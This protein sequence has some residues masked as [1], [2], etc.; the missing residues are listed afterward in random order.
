MELVAD[1]IGLLASPGTG[2]VAR[3]LDEHP[4]AQERLV[5]RLARRLESF[6][7]DGRALQSRFERQTLPAL[8]KNCAALRLW[9][10]RREVGVA[11]QAYRDAAEGETSAGSVRGAVAAADHILDRLAHVTKEVAAWDQALRTLRYLPRSSLKL[12]AAPANVK[13]DSS[14]E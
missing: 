7:E 5:F 11:P 9:L 13:A 12:P 2:P 4:G 3:A 1:K 8:K 10:H 14:T 6:R